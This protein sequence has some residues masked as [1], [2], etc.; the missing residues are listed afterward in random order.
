VEIQ[1]LNDQLQSAR[2]VS[3]ADSLDRQKSV[4]L[5]KKTEFLKEA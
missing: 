3:A 1:D 4:N 5:L 2:L